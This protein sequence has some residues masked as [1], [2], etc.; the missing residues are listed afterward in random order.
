M[1]IL[2]V[3][4]LLLLLLIATFIL[5]LCKRWKLAI[6][7]MVCCIGL[8]W[9]TETIPLN[10]FHADNSDDRD[11][12]VAAY[13]IDC[14]GWGEKHEGW[15]HD[16]IEFIAETNADILFLSEFQYHDFGGYTHLLDTITKTKFFKSVVDVKYGRKDVIYSKY[17]VKDFHRIDINSKFCESDSIYK[18]ITVDYYQKLLPMIY[19]MRVNAK[20]KDVQLVCCHLASNEFNVAKKMMKE[21]GLGAFWNNLN[22]GYVYR[23]VEVNSIVEA[24]DPSLPTILMGD[25]ND[26]NG[27]TTMSILQ[28]AGLQ[29]AWWQAGSG[30]GHTYY[31]QGLY[32]R[33]DHVLT[34]KDI[35]VLNVSVPTFNASDH[36]PILTDIRFKE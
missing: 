6:G 14:L 35:E 32:F 7:S 23:E 24:L 26:I 11:L 36:Y 18:E 27:S 9:W 19:Q 5:L 33:L 8:D 12:R 17:P 3:P 29:D 1:I 28:K 16:L 22:K 34:S 21:K 15:E 25:L 20:G 2:F 13:N 31:K 30:Y 4:I 10:L